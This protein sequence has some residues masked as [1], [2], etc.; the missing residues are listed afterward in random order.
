[1]DSILSIIKSL[2]YKGII[3]EYVLHNL[4]DIA[5][6]KVKDFIDDENEL[7]R[8][9]GSDLVFSLESSEETIIKQI[10]FNVKKA[11][12]WC[13]NVSFKDAPE[14]KSLNQVY[15]GLDYYVSPKRLRIENLEDSKLPFNSLLENI[16]YNTVV[17]GGPGAGKTTLMKFLCYRVLNEKLYE[18]IFTCPVVIR[19]RELRIP[20]KISDINDYNLY[21]ILKNELGIIV[22][23]ENSFSVN[24][25]VFDSKYRQILKR[26]I[27]DFIE[28]AKLLIILDG[29]DEIPNPK[30]K[31]IIKK[32]LE[33]LS[34][35]LD[36]SKFVL[37][38]RTGDFDINISNSATYEV[39]S[40]SKDQIKLFAER[41]LIDKQEAEDLY[42]QIMGSP[43][44]D[45]VIRPLTL[46]H[47]CAIYERYKKIPAKPKSVYNRVVQLLL[48]D[49]DSQRDI[50]RISSYASFEVDRK[51]EFLSKL[52]YI[53]TTRFNTAIFNRYDL[54]SAYR[55][56][57]QDFNLPVSQMRKVI[58]EIE[59]HNG[60][61]I[62]SGIE[63]YE[64]AHKSIQEFLA[65]KYIV[66]LPEIPSNFDLLKNIAN[67]IAIAVAISSDPNMYLGVLLLHKIK[68][69][70]YSPV[71]FKILFSRLLIE[72]P[73]YNDKPIF[74]VALANI[75]FIINSSENLQK[76][77][78][79]ELEDINS[80]IFNLL[81]EVVVK[82]SIKRFSKLYKYTGVGSSYDTFIYSFA[83]KN[84]SLGE[85]NYL[86]YS[87]LV[88]EVS[89]KYIN[90]HN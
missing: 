21:S 49:W 84:V 10:V 5:F 27:V 26:I 66:G 6:K 4:A 88:N 45:T 25:S 53:L 41:W 9:S 36:N 11:N 78:P 86:P 64:F 61:F 13:N 89:Y 81:E 60:L 31:Q 30:V 48:E 56:I 90:A 83:G 8:R 82:K 3:A 40:L 54:E 1:M 12:N 42:S 75:H 46:A 18:N 34:L 80:L 2:D 68:K 58:N 67:E 14:S 71:F 77:N 73:D 50:E 19:F 59:S 47:L 43:F 65:A 37:T 57:C 33:E 15:V 70:S 85:R 16:K 62:Q 39:C 55:A 24:Q 76:F 38:S 87:L 22:N 52:S 72:K 35:S 23:S 17:L 28:E 69:P 7:L 44:F 29:Y 63:S 51:I 20:K 79:F 32:D 74:F